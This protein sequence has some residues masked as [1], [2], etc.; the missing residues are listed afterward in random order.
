MRGH[1]GGGTRVTVDL[2]VVRPGEEPITI[3]KSRRCKRLH[4]RAGRPGDLSRDGTLLMRGGLGRTT[5]TRLLD[6][7]P[8]SNG[9]RRD[10]GTGGDREEPDKL[11]EKMW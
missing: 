11:E 6:I 8:C 2:E 1:A 7:L 9:V 10:P 5:E 3:C 4:Q